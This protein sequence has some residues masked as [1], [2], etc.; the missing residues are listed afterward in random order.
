[1]REMVDKRRLFI[2]SEQSVYKSTQ[3]IINPYFS[4][5]GE[6]QQLVYCQSR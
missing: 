2:T 5:L 3:L 6:S 1:M 4:P